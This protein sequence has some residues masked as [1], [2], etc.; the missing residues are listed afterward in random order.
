MANLILPV[1][2]KKTLEAND[3]LVYNGHVWINVSK[4][5]Y[6]AEFVNEINRLKN[7]QDDVDTLKTQVRELRGED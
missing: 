5:E 1:E 4:K 6:L 7:L 2:L 3:I